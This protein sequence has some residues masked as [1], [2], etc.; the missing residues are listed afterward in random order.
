[1]FSRLVFCACRCSVTTLTAWPVS[2]PGKHS[3]GGHALRPAHTEP[4]HCP[5]RARGPEGQV[6]F[7]QGGGTLLSGLPPGQALGAWSSSRCCRQGGRACMIRGRRGVRG[8]PAACTA[9]SA[10]ESPA[11]SASSSL[12]SSSSHSLF[13]FFPFPLFPTVF[14]L[15]CLF[16]LQNFFIMKK[17]PTHI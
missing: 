14:F 7:S 16:F 6:W 8:T 9:L 13:P 3:P 10:P 2:G 12:P 5:P 11:F 4:A 17:F 15:S 1:M